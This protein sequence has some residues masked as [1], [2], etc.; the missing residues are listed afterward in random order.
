M[1][2][3]GWVHDYG[4]MV[5]GRSVAESYQS[6]AMRTTPAVTSATPVM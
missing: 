3:E 2:G 5:L 1:N 6:R 4:F